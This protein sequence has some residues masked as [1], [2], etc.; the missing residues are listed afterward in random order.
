MDMGILSTTHVKSLS[1]STPDVDAREIVFWSHPWHQHVIWATV[2]NVCV[3][4]AE[5]LGTLQTCCLFVFHR[6]KKWRKIVTHVSL[7][8]YRKK[9]LPSPYSDLSSWNMLSDDGIQPAFRTTAAQ[10][11]PAP[12]KK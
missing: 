10:T 7:A 5:V 9:V 8:A 11:W 1:Y 2:G 3:S 4:T 12:H 6:T